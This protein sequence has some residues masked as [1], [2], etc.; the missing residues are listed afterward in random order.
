MKITLDRE[1][2]EPLFLY[3]F[4]R[5]SQGR[6]ELLK[7][8]SQVGT[9]G[10]AT[11]LTSLRACVVPVP[12]V[13][14]QAAIAQFLSLLDDRIDLLRQ[15]NATFESIAQALFKS[16]FIDFD[17]VRAKAEGREPEGMDAETAALF[18]DSFEDSA[19]GEI[20]KEWEC[21]RV[22]NLLELVYGKALKA[23]ERREGTIPVYGSGGVT[24]FHDVPLVKHGSVIVGRKGTVGSLY[25]ENG[26]FYPIDTTFY[27]KPKNVP[28]TYCYYAMQ[29]LGLES[30]NTDAAVPGL[31]RDNVYRL[32]LVRPN[33]EIFKVFDELVK[34]I[35]EAMHVNDIQAKIL[36]EIRD[37]L[38]PRL[39][40]GKLRLPE[41]EAQLNEALA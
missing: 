16:W 40:S 26:P 38:L 31:N 32:Q 36:S 33:V 17:P 8:A 4:F 5:S 22:D 41:A 3:Y 6:A 18:P 9:P 23:T 27:V 35:R 14:E 25:W 39:V 7:N 34:V 10:I 29:C 12:P 1:K 30:M 19:L 2:V 28:L 15:T 11:P 37:A 13:A 21:V 24:G 20:P